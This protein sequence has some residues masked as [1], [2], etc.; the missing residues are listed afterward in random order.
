MIY[1]YIY[2]ICSIGNQP[3]WSVCLS[4]CPSQD[5]WLITL[6]GLLSEDIMVLPYVPVLCMADPGPP[7]SMANP[8]MPL[9]FELMAELIVP[10]LLD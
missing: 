1:Q 7:P 4:I 5:T 6:S 9:L 2:Y 10:F 3:T 8:L